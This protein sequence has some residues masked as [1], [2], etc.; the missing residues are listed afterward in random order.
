VKT[1]QAILQNER[2]QDVP[3]TAHAR[4]FSCIRKP[5]V[6]S[7]NVYLLTIGDNIVF[8]DTGASQEV[9]DTACDAL[10][11][12]SYDREKP[13]II[14]FGHAHY[15]HIYEGLVDRRF[16]KFGKP[17][18]VCHASGADILRTGDQR[19]TQAYLVD[20][21]IPPLQIELPLF[22]NKN[23]DLEISEIL[24]GFQLIPNN[25][26]ISDEILLLSEELRFP[27]G[28]SLFFWAV[29][30]HSYDSMAIRIGNLLHVGDIPFALNPGVAGILGWDTIEFSKT[31]QRMDWILENY[32]ISVIC[33][34]HGNAFS[35]SEFRK[36]LH[37]LKQSHETLPDVALFD[38]GRVNLSMRHAMDLMDEAYRL[39][40]IVAG[41]IMLLRYHLEELEEFETAEDLERLIPVDDIE[42]TLDGFTTYYK[43]FQEKKLSE[44]Q[45]ILKSLQTLQKIRSY[46][47]GHTLEH[48]IDPSLVRRTTR[49][50]SDLLSAMQ[51]VIP[52]ARL[53]KC[54]PVLVLN[55]LILKQNSCAF[56]DDD[57]LHSIDDV[58]SFRNILLSRLAEYQNCKEIRFSI[59]TPDSVQFI[60]ADVDRLSDI[61]SA[62]SDY[63]RLYGAD[64]VN[65]EIFPKKDFVHIAITPVGVDW[66]PE[67][68]LSRA[69]LRTV[70]YAGGKIVKLPK[71]GDEEII[72][73]F[74][75]EK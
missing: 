3:G 24:P 35:V 10:V 42:K 47:T 20:L 14:I 41:R 52:T 55:D 15:D 45:V 66:K 56:S 48:L 62:L 59:K 44:L 46:L 54:D 7:S 2:W 38:K 58:T 5:D 31:L 64:S 60:Y 43:D 13:L 36:I 61:Y 25:I 26:H 23:Q 17:V 63:C 33:P 28:Q 6:T 74:P 69:L 67:L 29:P 70:R 65:V 22:H 68:P 34:G 19:Y 11:T 50:F 37:N 72:L 1:K 71:P 32:E 27:D 57:L 8:L 9:M 21:P 12:C 30:G 39:F 75:M 40:P 53:K 18:F 73:Q 51:G 4:I 16:E 49:L